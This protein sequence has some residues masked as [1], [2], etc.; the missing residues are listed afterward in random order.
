[1]MLESMEIEAFHPE[2]C[3]LGVIQFARG[4][5]SF[6]NDTRHNASTT[7]LIEE[8]AF[9]AAALAPVLN[10]CGIQAPA[11]LNHTTNIILCL[12]SIDKSFLLAIQIRKDL[13]QG[14]FGALLN[15]IIK[16]SGT[17]SI[18]MRTCKHLNDEEE[19]SLQSVINFEDF[20]IKECLEAS[21][22]ITVIV[23][24]LQTAVANKS[25]DAI[26]DGVVALS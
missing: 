20:N 21:E 11:F 14:H 16:F 13:F 15:D 3:A 2:I 19:Q 4:V 17:A 26:V 9:L 1:M 5:Q 10:N 22:Q 24:E 23:E 25:A 18:A 8:I 12:T 7:V 6:A